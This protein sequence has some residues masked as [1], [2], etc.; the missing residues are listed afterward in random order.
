[1][2]TFLIIP[3]QCSSFFLCSYPILRISVQCVLMGATTLSIMTLSIM[4]FSLIDSQNNNA[5]LLC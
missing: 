3:P 1:M 2:K 5:L 4:K